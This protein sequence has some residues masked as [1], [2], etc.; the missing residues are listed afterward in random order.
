MFPQT[1]EQWVFLLAACVIGLLIGQFI[2]HQRQKNNPVPGVQ[3][4]F[5]RKRLSKKE[6]RKGKISS[7]G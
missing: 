7:K 6:R 5:P 2:R 4:T 1:F 3:T